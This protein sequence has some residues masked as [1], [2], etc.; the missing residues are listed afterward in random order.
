[1]NHFQRILTVKGHLSHPCRCY[2][3]LIC[4]PHSWRKIESYTKKGFPGGSDGK[5]SACNAGDPG[6][7]HESGR[8][9]GEGN[10]KPTPEFLPGEFHGQ[11]SLAGYSPC[12]LKESDM[13][14]W[15][16]LYTRKPNCTDKLPR[17][18]SQIHGADKAVSFFFFCSVQLLCISIY[19]EIWVNTPEFQESQCPAQEML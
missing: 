12:V 15:L 5:E 1:M 13:T 19:T 14:E 3:D 2:P 17:C 10:G 7:M 8:S 11:R 16:T 4:A 6:S 18:T 9:P